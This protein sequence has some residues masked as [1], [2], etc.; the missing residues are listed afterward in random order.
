MIKKIL[1]LAL[2]LVFTLSGYSYSKKDKIKKVLKGKEASSIKLLKVDNILGYVEVEGHS[3]REIVVEVEQKLS[4]DTEKDLKK[5]EEEVKLLI[6][7]EGDTLNIKVDG[8][9][10]NQK[11]CKRNSG[12]VFKRD[13]KFHNNIRVR[14][15]SETDIDIKTVTEGNI[16]ISNIKGDFKVN[17]VNGTVNMSGINGSG[18][19]K[20]ISGKVNINFVKNPSKACKMSTISGRINLVFPEK[21]DAEFSFKSMT[22]EV[23]SDFDYEYLG[24]KIERKKSSKHNSFKYISK[25]STRVRIGKGGP[26]IDLATMSGDIILSKRK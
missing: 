7:T 2:M 12:C 1:L 14:I 4:G 25:R 20:T 10:R 26:A 3:G 24:N 22:G 19:A 6:E 16:E 13:Y 17:H 15:P 21:P 23:L 5:A 18:T 9:F 8:P 11:C